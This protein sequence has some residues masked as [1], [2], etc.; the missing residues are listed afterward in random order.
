MVD[1][2]P[3]V[4]QFG[5]AV[6]E[7]AET[8]GFPIVDLNADHNTGIVSLRTFEQLLQQIF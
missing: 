3:F 6:I 8:S 1:D 4:S 5:K 7:A 2:I